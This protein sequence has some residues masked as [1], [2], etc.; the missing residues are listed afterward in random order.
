MGL[1]LGRPTSIRSSM[2]D[3]LEEAMT[4]KEFKPKG[5]QHAIELGSQYD[6]N[7]QDVINWI[8]QRGLVGQ[9]GVDDIEAEQYAPGPVTIGKTTV[10]STLD[11][12]MKYKGKWYAVDFKYSDNP[13]DYT[14]QMFAQAKTIAQYKGV[15]LEEV[16]PMLVAVNKEAGKGEWEKTQADIWRAIRDK[17]SQ[18]LSQEEAEKATEHVRDAAY[19]KFYKTVIIDPFVASLEGRTTGSIS[20][21]IKGD[22]SKATED[23]VAGRAEL[24]L[25][26]TQAMYDLTGV[27]PQLLLGSIKQEALAPADFAAYQK[28]QTK[29]DEKARKVAT[30]R[31]GGQRPDLVQ[32][33]VELQDYLKV[34]GQQ[35]PYL[36][37]YEQKKLEAANVKSFVIGPSGSIPNY[38]HK[39]VDMPVYFDNMTGE[40]KFA[41]EKKDAL[42][43]FIA[44]GTLKFKYATNG[45]LIVNNHVLP[46]GEADLKRIADKAIAEFTKHGGGHAGEQAFNR[47]VTAEMSGKPWMPESGFTA[48]YETKATNLIARPE[49]SHQYETVQEMY[50]RLQKMYPDDPVFF[51]G[52]NKAG[53][54]AQPALQAVGGFFVDGRGYDAK[55]Y[56]GAGREGKVIK[57]TQ[58]AFRDFVLSVQGRQF[59][60]A[61]QMEG[62]SRPE[63]YTAFK[64]FWTNIDEINH[65]SRET[66]KGVMGSSH[67][68]RII[69]ISNGG[70]F[71]A[72]KTGDPNIKFENG[73]LF[74][75]ERNGQVYGHKERNWDDIKVDNIRTFKKNGQAYVEIIGTGYVSLAKR[76]T[77]NYGADKGIVSA[78]SLYGLENQ[79][80]EMISTIGG[81]YRQNLHLVLDSLYGGEGGAAKMRTEMVD[82]LRRNDKARAWLMDKYDLSS[83]QAVID[84][85]QKQ[86]DTDEGRRGFV[87]GNNK[88]VDSAMWWLGNEKIGGMFHTERMEMPM[89]RAGYNRMRRGIGE[90]DP[91]NPDSEGVSLID[92]SMWNDDDGHYDPEKRVTVP[93]YARGLSME[94]MGHTL[95][96]GFDT[97]RGRM[98]TE[99]ILDF[100]KNPQG[101]SDY[102]AE[103]LTK[104]ALPK[105]LAK[106]AF[107]RKMAEDMLRANLLNS[108]LITEDE[109][110]VKSISFSDFQNAIVARARGQKSTVRGTFFDALSDDKFLDD[111][112]MRGK[113]IN[114]DGYYVAPAD[115][116]GLIGRYPL[117]DDPKHGSSE[118]TYS[119]NPRAKKALQDTL[120]AFM[121][122]TGT[123]MDTEDFQK[124]LAF[125]KDRNNRLTTARRMYQRAFSSEV[126]T[127]KMYEMNPNIPL[128]TLVIGN[129]TAKLMFGTTDVGKIQEA[130]SSGRG[131]VAGLLRRPSSGNAMA[132][133]QALR[134]RLFS[135]FPEEYDSDKEGMVFSS[136]LG[137][138]GAG[139]HG[140][141]PSDC[142]GAVDDE[143]RRGYHRCALCQHV[144]RRATS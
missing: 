13:H 76:T 46:G 96:H 45:T 64:T 14:G 28:F 141:R 25:M 62:A 87:W 56:V 142:V 75:G 126:G 71:K 102:Y 69:P 86:I 90:W 38:W 84:A 107:N 128:G 72:Y 112:G 32:D 11:S 88:L 10:T 8:R 78:T 122:L 113:F 55:V 39:A 61:I 65:L 54:R 144:V 130:V 74:I 105:L 26:I 92:K 123:D 16:M 79:G 131:L 94:R 3:W 34:N 108:G 104:K 5:V 30:A 125:F 81:N 4:S 85:V 41:T 31:M 117:G 110:G 127:E 23:K 27:N 121:R 59:E 124:R 118:D 93:V 140:R 103:A 20:K 6:A 143:A 73:R 53:Y 91:A 136:D 47:A 133:M 22:V 35:L 120:N 63:S 134:V 44:A 12:A 106:G 42:G 70:G 111:T 98:S 58:K 57:D 109:L 24:G 67:Y 80:Y 129:R 83:E 132:S 33:R 115:I 97:G 60:G 119:E 17:M 15:N 99:E 138:S 66:A 18:G 68:R 7:L 89:T 29:L 19:V 135:D 49:K 2:L 139:R 82:M 43:N 100:V 116:M 1:N 48:A 137:R 50:A 101:Y 40:M 77:K 9:L 51:R 21:V 36:P 52:E 95:T 114:V 37:V